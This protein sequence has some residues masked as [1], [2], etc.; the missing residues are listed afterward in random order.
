M[1]GS[2]VL[3]VASV[4][5]ALAGCAGDGGGPSEGTL[6]LSVADAPVDAAEGVVVQ[7]SGVEI[8]PAG[9]E[10]I[11]V[12]LPPRP[13]DLLTLT[14]GESE[15][16]L[17]GLLLPAGRYDWVRLT[18][19]AQEGLADS[20]IVVDGV[21]RELRIPSGAESGLKVN[22]GFVVPAGGAADFTVD[23][24]LRK[25]VH[26]SHQGYEL[27]PTLRM[28]DNVLVGSVSGTVAP[29]LLADPSCTGGYA[30]YVYGSP[31]AAVLPDD[32][33][34]AMLPPLTT[35]RVEEGPAGVF[36]YRAAF[37]EAGDYTVAFTCQAAADDPATDDDIAL[38]GAAL[39]AV[40]AHRDT[41]HDF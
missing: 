28:V 41:V 3:A 8:Q 9:G 36:T 12:D 21:E 19:D 34:G 5:A 1:K 17:P 25:S 11:A 27:R 24:D 7:F 39:V 30:V 16:L 35:A 26:L 38:V 2:A 20:F 22:R 14:G 15:L 31:A 4:L 10:R 23:F 37:L 32:L 29:S 18:V 13:L 6:R 40:T 33:G